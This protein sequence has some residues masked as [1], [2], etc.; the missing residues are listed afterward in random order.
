MFSIEIT[1]EYPHLAGWI[2]PGSQT[3]ATKT[4]VS[5]IGEIDNFEKPL[6]HGRCVNLIQYFQNPTNII[7]LRTPKLWKISTKSLWHII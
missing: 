2:G 3:G 5:H 7:I 4:W 1:A 6:Q